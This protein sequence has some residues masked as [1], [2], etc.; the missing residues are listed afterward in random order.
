MVKTRLFPLGFA[1]LL[2]SLLVGCIPVARGGAG[3]PEVLQIAEGAPGKHVSL[4]VLDTTLLGVFSDRE[5]TT[6][7]TFQVPIGPHLLTDAPAATVLDKIDVT[8]P[9]SPVFGEHVLAV[10]GNRIE[11]M[12]AARHNE[13]RTVLKLAYRDFDSAQWKLDIVDPPGDPVALLPGKDSS[14]ALF[15]ASSALLSR[16]FASM[17]SP[18]KVRE[19][20]QIRDRASTFSPTGFTVFDGASQTLMEV[21]LGESGATFRPIAGAFEVHSS[22]LDADGKLAVL[23]WDARSRRLR[24]LEE[25]PGKPDFSRTTVT[26]CDGTA[27]VALLPPHRRAGFFF[28]FDE[29]R[30]SGA[31]STEHQ[32]SLLSPSRVLGGLGTRYEKSVV[33]SGPLPVE[34]FFAVETPDAI[35]VLA[36]QGTL[37]LIRIGLPL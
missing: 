6:L 19:P 34:D 13:D 11:V 29:V 16:T 23:T 5:S 10:T 14:L 25:K 30:R 9:L 22:I 33:L 24:L 28:L 12:Y 20:F 18:V 2:L 7:K 31:G 3:H 27:T 21:T 37:K 36:L 35:Y 26:L 4:A 17:D 8:P 1:P 15:W 32:L